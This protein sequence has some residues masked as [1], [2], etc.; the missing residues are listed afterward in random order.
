M[1]SIIRLRTKFLLFS[2]CLSV[3]CIEYIFPSYMYTE[4]KSHKSQEERKYRTKIKIRLLFMQIT[5]YIHVHFYVG[6]YKFCWEHLREFYVY[7]FWIIYA[8]F[9]L[10]DIYLVVFFLNIRYFLIPILYILINLTHFII[11]TLYCL[12]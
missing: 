2:K 7:K 1:K 6:F 4:S 5:K 3:H 8:T 12:R 10:K 9:V 11:S